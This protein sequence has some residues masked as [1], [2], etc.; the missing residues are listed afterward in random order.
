MFYSV[1]H[2]NFKSP[3]RSNMASNMADSSEGSDIEDTELDN[4]DE[5][6]NLEENILPSDRVV[7]EQWI[8][9]MFG[10]E[11][12]LSEFEG[13]A[14]EWKSGN[15][16]SQEKIPFNRQPGIKIELP[17]PDVITPVQVFSNIFTE[18]MW[19]RLITQTNLYAEQTR[20]AT[21]SNSK[22]DPVTIHEMKTFVGLC[23]AMGILELPSRR[24]FW[25]QKK[26]LFRTSIPQ[27]MSRDRFAIIWR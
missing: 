10:E 18:E 15:F 2:L 6:D 21:P 1:G 8:Q 14:N 27:A 17:M 11:E 25:R 23:L 20:S 22:W 16:H 26:W 13:F 3:K 9:A 24:D 12:D 5:L 4:L 19:M 7:R